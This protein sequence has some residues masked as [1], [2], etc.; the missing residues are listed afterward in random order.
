M[1]YSDVIFVKLIKQSWIRMLNDHRLI[2]DRFRNRVPIMHCQ[3]TP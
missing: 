3:K 2:D 1:M